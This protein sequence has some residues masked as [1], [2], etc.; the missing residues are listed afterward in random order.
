MKPSKF[1]VIGAGF[2]ARFQIPAWREVRGAELVALC[3]RDHA[4]AE[5]AARQFGV[6]K[7]YADA[8]ELLRCEPLDFIDIAA[9]PQTH[10]ALVELAARHRVPVICQK[11]MALDYG[12]CERMVATCRTAGVPFLIHE[13]YRWQTPMR[14]LKQLL[15]EGRIGRPFRAHIQ[16]SH[17]D[18]SLYNNQPYLFTDPHFA[19]H[20]MGPHLLD[21]PR[22]FFGEPHSLYAREFNVHPKF[23][24]ED[25]VSI[26]LGYEKL[27]CHCELSWRTTPYQAFIE[28]RTGTLQW[29]TDGKLTIANDTGGSIEQLAPQTYPWADSRYGFAHPSIVATNGHLLAALRSEQAAETTGEDNLKTMRLVFAA[30]DSAARSEAVR[31][32]PT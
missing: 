26:M 2:W 27:T 21:L 32:G 17:A 22:F 9:S 30:Q 13:N 29:R 14:R 4:K 16:F 12:T 1:A 7:V 20:D 11:P 15:N 3:D 23:K 8:E 28:G 10:A 24:G 25:I 31:L 5:T 6:P 18:L 19:L